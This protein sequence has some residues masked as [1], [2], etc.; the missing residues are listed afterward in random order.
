MRLFVRLF[1][2]AGV[3]GSAYRS[4]SLFFF[5]LGKEGIYFKRAY[6][7][8]EPISLAVH[9]CST[10]ETH[11]CMAESVT[12]LQRF[13]RD[14]FKLEPKYQIMLCGHKPYARL[15]TKKPLVVYFGDVIDAGG[16]PELFV[17]DRK[18]LASSASDKS[19]RD[20]ERFELQPLCTFLGIRRN[21][22]STAYDLAGSSPR[23]SARRL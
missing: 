12:A 19:S 11:T 1:K 3:A 7:M 20:A 17:F 23:C 10:G 9:W 2:Q 15:Q 5:G 16:T 18:S 8:A 21:L 6:T 4:A 22:R 14:F 13:V